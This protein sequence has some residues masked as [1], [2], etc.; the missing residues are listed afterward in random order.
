MRRR[1]RG[2]GLKEAKDVEEEEEEDEKEMEDEDEDEGS[3]AV[4]RVRMLSASER[5]GKFYLL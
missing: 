4:Y 5:R 1:T 3:Y 2:G